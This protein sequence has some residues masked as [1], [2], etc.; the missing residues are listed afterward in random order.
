[1]ASISDLLDP[2][3]QLARD[4]DIVLVL[5]GGNALG[6][7]EAGVYEALHDGGLH[8]NW[9][10]GASIGAINGA[11]IAG[12]APDRR[13]N[14]LRAFWRPDEARVAGTAGTW[15]LEAAD[16]GRRTAAAS[17]TMMA[18]R[19]GI[20]GPMLSTM[21]PFT[22]Q[23]H[24]LFETDQLERTLDRMVDFSRLNS[25]DCRFTATAV[26]LETG[27][28]VFYDTAD[29]AIEARHIRASAALPVTFP[30]VEI[31]GRWLVDGGLSANL[32]LDPLLADPP[33][34]PVL[35]IAVDLLPLSG[36]LP[37]TLGEAASRMQDLVF[38]AQSR[39]TIARWRESYGSRDDVSITLLRIAYTDQSNE[40]AGKAMDFSRL[41][42]RQR[43]KSGQAAVGSVIE[44][45]VAQAA[46]GVP[47]LCIIG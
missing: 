30:P 10:I 47:G 45:A 38:A 40:V 32:P 11:L 8:P 35:C 5:S 7:F 31:D 9:I 27:E 2:Q 46:N 34:R 29:R 17:W 23:Q 21:L 28:D 15:L 37:A 42:I 16:V 19:P 39:R 24:S 36:T 33:S 44:A 3:P 4:F 18:G 12:A 1:M 20:F 25:G 14:V 41:T 43:W 26:D 13:V 22:G 6:A